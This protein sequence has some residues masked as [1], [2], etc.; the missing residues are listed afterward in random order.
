MTGA[1]YGYMGMGM[2][3]RQLLKR[4]KVAVDG[5]KTLESFSGLDQGS[6]DWQVHLGMDAPPSQ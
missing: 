2:D 3:G 5:L 6:Q 4:R 1:E